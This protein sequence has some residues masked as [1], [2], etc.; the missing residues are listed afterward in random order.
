MSLKA[1]ATDGNRTILDSKPLV[2]NVNGCCEKTE[3]F[4]AVAKK[5]G[6]YQACIASNLPVTDGSSRCGEI[7]L[8]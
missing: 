3:Q 6:A 2:L 8:Q 5:P 7:E 1:H 4:L